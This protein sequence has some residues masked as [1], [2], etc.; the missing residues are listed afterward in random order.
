VEVDFLGL[1]DRAIKRPRKPGDSR[2]QNSYRARRA[3]MNPYAVSVETANAAWA[4][5]KTVVVDASEI[6]VV[7]V[8]RTDPVPVTVD[9]LCWA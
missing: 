3:Q 8:G 1:L 7:P 9:P 5:R 6:R 4:T 2:Q